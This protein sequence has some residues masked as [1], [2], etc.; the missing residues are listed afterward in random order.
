M[1]E[2]SPTGKSNTAVVFL[3]ISAFISSMGFGLAAPVMP[4]LVMAVTGGSVAEAARWGGVAVF[5][6]AAMQ[7]IFSPIFG[8]LSDRFGRRPVLIVSL[9][10]FAVD[11]AAL[12]LVTTLWAFLLV[13]ALAGVFA[14]TFST[15]NAYIAD[16]TPRDKR[17]QRFALIGA[18]FGAGFIFG[19]AIGG[20]LGDIDVRLPF[21]AGAAVAGAN[22]LFGYFLL[23]E[24][25]PRERRRAFSWSR[26]NT[27]GTLVQLVRTAG[28]GV[29]LPVF[30]FATLS[31]W[32]YPTVWAYVAIERFSWSTQAI[33]YSVAYYGVIAFISS[34]VVVQFVLPRLG[35]A[36]AI[37]IALAFEVVALT[38]IGL[39]TEGWMVYAMITLALVSTM[40]DPAIR[41]ELSARVAE[42]AQ[43]ELQGGLSALTSIAMILAPLT[44]MGLFTATAGEG[45]VVYFPGS[46]FIAAAA[47]SL[48]TLV[49]YVF[50]EKRL[51]ALG[52]V[53]E[54]DPEKA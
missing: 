50:A 23:P 39:A 16:V 27:I 2:T 52:S 14:S 6:Y 8:A 31:S 26:A 48:L 19:P 54:G 49:L 47:M 25:L 40:Q 46:P 43:G 12:A 11:M 53:E 37:L 5:S 1:T 3:V 36:K 24:S 20:I 21:F 18:A 42:D 32:V 30:F 13:R 34:A 45:A 35:V 28:I 15:T 4:E 41:Q 17:G 7:F 10:A 29:L 33:G 44:Y 9:V 38:G 51:P 22:A